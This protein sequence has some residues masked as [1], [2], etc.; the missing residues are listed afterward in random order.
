MPAITE[1]RDSQRAS[2]NRFSKGWKKWDT[3][4]MDWLSPVGAQIISMAQLKPT[5]RVLDVASGTGEPGLSAAKKVP[6]GSVLAVDVAE[7]MLT[8]AQE[9]STALGLKNFSVQHHDGFKLPDGP[10]DAVV[11]RFGLMFFPDVEAGVREIRRVCKKGAHFS[12]SVWLA[13]PKNPWAAVSGKVVHELLNLPMPGPDVP[14]IF[15][16]AAPGMT[17]DLFQK[18]GFTDVTS[19]EVSGT[20]K[21]RSADHYWEYLLDIVAPVSMALTNAPAE[22]VEEVHQAIV[23]AIAPFQAKEGLL[24]PWSAKVTAGVAK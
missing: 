8:V 20:L 11:A 5:D 23:K 10:F 18:A 3:F 24:F 19:Q 22:K 7:D 4:V 17:E 13:G 6:Q 9:K 15:R 1:I 16:C 12:A 14:S 21:F 2:W